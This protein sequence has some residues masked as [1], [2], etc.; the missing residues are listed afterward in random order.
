M[1]LLFALI[2]ITVA[3]IFLATAALSVG[4]T[5]FVIFASDIIVAVFVIW[6]AFY[7]LGKHKRKR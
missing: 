4:G 7:C 2:F 3:I 1:I 6:L 5:L